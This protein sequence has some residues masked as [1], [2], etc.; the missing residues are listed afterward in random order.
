MVTPNI[1]VT[2]TTLRNRFILNTLR[3][4]VDPIQIK[5]MLGLKILKSL[6]PYINFFNELVNK[7]RF[8]TRIIFIFRNS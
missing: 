8:K 6:Y 7:I 1:H 2:P 5:L 3:D 4:G